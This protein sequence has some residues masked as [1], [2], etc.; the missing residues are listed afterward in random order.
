MTESRNIFVLNLLL[1]VAIVVVL[2]VALARRQSWTPSQQLLENTATPEALPDIT[3]IPSSSEPEY[4]AAAMDVETAAL[5]DEIAELKAKIAEEDSRRKEFEE[6]NQQK[7]QEFMAKARKLQTAQMDSSPP[8]SLTFDEMVE[9]RDKY[10]AIYEIIA[11]KIL[12]DAQERI[13]AR[14]VIRDRLSEAELDDQQRLKVLEYLDELDEFDRNLSI[15]N[16][17]SKEQQLPNNLEIFVLLREKAFAG[18]PKV[19]LENLTHAI[20]NPVSFDFTEGAKAP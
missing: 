6:S 17:H 11:E 10:P 13:E 8:I 1:C 20:L 7:F 2:A 14:Q 18:Q 15:Q 16:F 19:T 3:L 9:Q 12:L 5:R 4:G